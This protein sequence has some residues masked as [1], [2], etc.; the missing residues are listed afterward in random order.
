M[1]K[2]DCSFQQ[3]P[4]SNLFNNYIH[5]FEKVA[6]FYRYN[7][8]DSADLKKRISELPEYNNRAEVISALAAYHNHL[9]I[10]EQQQ[11]ALQKLA[12]PQAL[13][14]VTGQQLGMYG[15]PLFTMYKT[16]TAIVLAKKW[17]KELNKPV[18]P[19]FW[20]AD[21]DHDFDEIASVGIP[22]ADHFESI[23]IE[24]EGEGKPVS[25][26]QLP[27]SITEFSKRVFANLPET[28]FTDDLR[29]EL[30]AIYTPGSFHVQSFAK[31][32]NRWFA[33]HGVLIVGSQTK[34][35]KKLCVEQLVAA[36]EQAAAIEQALESQS[37]LLA[38][39]FHA[40]VNVGHSNLFYLDE[41]QR[42]IKID[43]QENE[44]ISGEKTWTK[45][46]LINHIK[47][48]PEQFSPNVFLRPVLQDILLPTVGYVAGPGELAY[49]G[50]MKS[51][52]QQFGLHMPVIVPRLSLTLI[53]SGI[54]RIMDKLPFQMC[55]YNQRIEDLEKAYID[56]SDSHDVDE[57]FNSWVKSVQE[58]SGSVLELIKDIDPT[59]EGSVGKVISGIENEANKLKGRVF[60]SLKQQEGTQLNRIARIKAQLFPDGLQER[61]VSPVYFENKYGSG[62]WEAI[63]SQ[64]EGDRLDLSKHHILPLHEFDS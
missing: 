55:T 56:Q 40:Q 63:I 58:T 29:Y 61:S 23:R 57:V 54:E 14:F 28:D 10:A 5:R 44:W 26:E 13:V 50:Q 33:K 21:E 2:S 9:G 35:I 48:H 17:E 37:A 12:D 46:A 49:F 18:I 30:E 15:G 60:R 52:Y 42:R 25:E 27:A 7:P 31:L 38:K 45:S 53:E 19:V 36:V 24:Q 4:F 6:D 32:M 3:L 59:L 1:D 22:L 20:L 8:F 64:F 16:F 47:N 11:A 41:N 34:A 39:N 62:L 43:I 51:F